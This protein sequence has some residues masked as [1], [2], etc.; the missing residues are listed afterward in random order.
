MGG[1]VRRLAAIALVMASLP[2]LLW[3]QDRQQQVLVLYSTGRDSEIA[4]TG[5]RELAR[6]IEHGLGRSIDYYSEYID[7]GRFPD[8]RYREAFRDFLERKYSTLQFEVVI[9]VLDVAIEFLHEYRSEL[10]GQAPIV[11]ITSGPLAHRLPNS[12]GVVAETNYA[13][14]VTLATE[15][16]PDTTQLFVV[17]GAG[18]RD[19]LYAD[20]VREQFRGLESQLTIHYLEGLA[21]DA[22]EQR[23]ARLP[24]HSI[25]FYVIVYQDQKGD[26]FEP[27]EYLDRLTAVAN[28]PIYSWVDSAL[29]HGV[30]GGSLRSIQAEIEAVSDRAI[31]VLR[32]RPA[33]DIPIVSADL[34]VNQVDWRQLRRWGIDESMVP[35]GTVVRFREPNAWD[36]YSHYVLGAAALLL[37]QS[38]L[39]AGLLVQAARR[40]KAEKEMRLSQAALQRS[41]ERIHD[42]GARLLNAQE[43]ERSR[44]ARELHDDISPQL[45]LLR[46]DLE[47]IVGASQSRQA[48]LPTLAGGALG[49]AQDVAKSVHDLSHDLHPARL[50][51]MGLVASL[52]SLQRE[53]STSGLAVTFMHE[54]VP[55]GL[56]YDLALCIYRIVQEGIRNAAKHSGA[57]L[58]SVRLGGNGEELVL[59]IADDGRGFDANVIQGKG[60]GLISMRERL[61]PLGG[62]LTIHTRPGRGTRLEITVP[63]HPASAREVVADPGKVA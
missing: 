5:E 62:A 10:F 35:P 33:A 39:I 26:K 14:T 44:I 17:G 45:A 18:V 2:G 55:A 57:Q 11:F 30:V 23:L 51:L 47:R 63:I 20:T 43:A 28:R 7:G 37:A 22:L 46:M 59:T 58:V 8:P 48:E 29:A 40:R 4:R 36:T 15:L 9:G 61:D 52:E 41:V 6:L 31:Q 42:L 1:R 3:A 19:K 53:F 34:E 50:Q 54:D 27:L 24:E 32:G 21:T 60:L 56:S 13:S 16:Q 12:T 38:A 49:R 25:V